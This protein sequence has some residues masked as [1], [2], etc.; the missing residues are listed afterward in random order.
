MEIESR[1]A[2][3]K[4]L[5]SLSRRIEQATRV[6]QSSAKQLY[7]HA[8]HPDGKS[9]SKIT[10]NQG[11]ALIAGDS[12]P[13]LELIYAVH[14]HFM[15][16]S[17]HYIADTFEHRLS[18]TF[19]VRPSEDIQSMQRIIEWVRKDDPVLD[20]FAAKARIII[21]A[22]Q[23][24]KQK[25]KGEAPTRVVFDRNLPK[26]NDTDHEIINFIRHYLR[27]RRELQLNPCTLALPSILNK[28]SPS[29]L[30][31]AG[32][33]AFRLLEDLTFFAPWSD[34]ASQDVDL[35]LH[36]FTDTIDTP[37]PR[38]DKLP[39]TTPV[40]VNDDRISGAKTIDG[41][42]NM[43][44][45]FGNLAVYVIDDS[46]AEELDDGVSIERTTDGSGNV[47]L[48]VHIADPTSVLRPDD[49]VALDAARR[50]AT[51]YFPEG[52]YPMLPPTELSLDALV[53]KKG[54]SINVLTFSLLVNPSGDIIDHNVR[55]SLVRRVH[56]MRYDDI[57]LGL[58]G[59][60]IES[61]WPFGEPKKNPS[62]SAPRPIPAE[63]LPDLQLLHQ[64]TRTMAKARISK[65]DS[66]VW[67]QPKAIVSM[68]KAK[69]L[70]EPDP[71]P[72][73][74][75]YRGFPG[76]NYAVQL[77]TMNDASHAL[78][79]SRALVAECMIGAGRIASLFAQEHGIPMI[80]RAL[81]RPAGAAADKYE[82]LL[83]KRDPY[84]GSILYQDALIRQL[85][86]VTA[87]PMLTPGVHW[88]LGIPEHEGYVRATS[89]LRRYLDMLCHWQI[90]AALHPKSLGV[91]PPFSMDDL[92]A[93]M[94]K[95]HL[96]EQARRRAG[97]T[98]ILLW[99]M[100][101]IQNQIASGGHQALES[102][103]GIVLGRPMNLAKSLVS[104]V[105]VMVPQIGLPAG[106][107][108]F[109]VATPPPIG[110]TVKVEIA[111]MELGYNPRL[112]VRLKRF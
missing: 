53:G 98:S 7:E 17:L 84:Q 22:S 51:A 96:Q 45:D 12:T 24:I 112:L 23:S 71:R 57:T 2:L 33:S 43:R 61:T 77:G 4:S 56:V 90:K 69:I 19:S 27:Q 36:E 107:T 48:H 5:R 46:T 28:I 8:K 86:Q 75:L 67:S 108:G 88:Q 6:V 62:D 103:E 72:I 9:W 64:V 31:L 16:D 44:H 101:Y 85:A 70:T 3:G 21:E 104:V 10:L 42:D 29:Y 81:A 26:L 68:D 49:P 74:R 47:W 91:K 94:M 32:H 41:L 18:N 79:L 80:Y 83:D 87:Q 58:G 54:A 38:S 20:E 55:A 52:T 106:L 63:D 65:T 97:N 37:L 100:R 15:E 89:P 99:A 25:S 109:S 82:A 11:V 1:I 92:K 59:S 13:N 14:Q 30:P 93:M 66:I 110:S 95:Q 40:T 73:P 105:P 78:D 102:L 35:Q 60:L 76:I 34:H 39:T 111:D 50:A